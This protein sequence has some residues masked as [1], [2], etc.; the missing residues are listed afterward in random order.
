MLFNAQE[1]QIDLDDTEKLNWLRL[2]RTDNV[3]PI[4][5]YRLIERFGTASKALEALPEF[6]KRG[7]R[8]KPLTAPPVGQIEKE[9]NAL[10]KLGGDIICACEE[11]Y[12][13]PLAATEDAPPVISVFGN[14][15]L[16]KR[17]GIGMVGA[18]NASLNGRKFA[19]KLARELGQ[20]GQVVISGLARGIDTAAHRGSIETG[21]IA[22]VAGGVD[23]IY[24]QENTELYNVIRERGLIVA[25]SPLGTQPV[26]RHFPKRNRIISGLSSGV[27]VV[28]ATLKSGSLITARM[29]GEQGRDVYAVPGFPLDP[30]AAGPNKLLQDGAVLIQSS[31]DVLQNMNDF[32]GRSLGEPK[33]AEAPIT[34][35][36]PIDENEVEDA[37]DLILSNLSHVPVTVDELVRVCHITISVAQ[38]VL[39]ELELAGRLQRLP[40]GR[41]SLIET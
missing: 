22:V 23:V 40:G 7:G 15:D 13:L 4:T 14:A 34:P 6:S 28:E 37:R 26:A 8:S 11:H 20:S 25:E 18:R 39:L 33:Q 41:V 17:Q 2:I 12:P 21:T 35:L 10:H 1:K 9:L 29:A 31:T 32:T 36:A 16:L 19:E 5:F 38:T 30:R 24:P 27:V 3:G